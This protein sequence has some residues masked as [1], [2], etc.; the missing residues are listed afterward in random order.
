MEWLQDSLIFNPSSVVYDTP[1]E[2]EASFKFF[3]K[4]VISEVKKFEYLQAYIEEVDYNKL[5]IFADLHNINSDMRVL[6][7]KFFTDIKR[8]DSNENDKDNHKECFSLSEKHCILGTNNYL[9]SLSHNKIYCKS[10]LAMDNKHVAN[11]YN[12][13]S[14]EENY[15][16]RII[17]RL[18]QFFC[19]KKRKCIEFEREGVDALKIIFHKN[20]P[21]EY[22]KMNAVR[23]DTCLILS[24]VLI[25]QKHWTELGL[26]DE[27][28]TVKNN[29]F[30]SDARKV[31]FD[32]VQR[33]I[34]KHI[35]I[36]RSIRL[37]LDKEENN[38]LVGH[39]TE[40]LPTKKY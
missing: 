7:S 30:L 37:Y 20:F 4:E 34:F 3:L 11:I 35:R 6:V 8:L 9:L 27:S 32:D 33:H 1:K 36:S 17:W 31:H 23:K 19:T 22:N 2:M 13:E 15:K 24:E 29:S 28:E 21:D 38:I 12:K 14:F 40:H 25:G 39:L 16:K 26:Q 5:T 18:D 10:Q